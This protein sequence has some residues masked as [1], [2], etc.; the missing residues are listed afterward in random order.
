LQGERLARK[1]QRPLAY[2]YLANTLVDSAPAIVD[3]RSASR[4]T[5]FS[6]KTLFALRRIHLVQ[7]SAFEIQTLLGNTS[8]DVPGIEED[9]DIHRCASVL[10]SWLGLDGSHAWLLRTVALSRLIKRV[11]DLGVAVFQLSMPPKE[12]QRVLVVGSRG[13]GGFMGLLMGSV[14]T[15]CVHHSHCPVLVVRESH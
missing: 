3:N 2:F 1:L 7:S 6:P 13:V 15:Q 4:A 12:L 11:E 5:E 10:R 14:S 8:P 9:W